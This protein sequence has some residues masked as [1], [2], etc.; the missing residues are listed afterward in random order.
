MKLSHIMPMDILNVLSN[1]QTMFKNI[2]FLFIHFY[3]DFC[4][5]LS[6]V[7]TVVLSK[8]IYHAR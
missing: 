8:D 2:G 3:M 4:H 7:I 5:C 6:S 1:W